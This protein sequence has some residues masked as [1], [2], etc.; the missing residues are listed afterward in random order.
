MRRHDPDSHETGGALVF[1]QHFLPI[2]P[3]FGI[4][5]L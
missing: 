4:A 3:T 2:L 5:D 1:A